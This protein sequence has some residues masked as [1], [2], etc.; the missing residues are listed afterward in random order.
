MQEVFPNIF[1]RNL[2]ELHP[3]NGLHEWA[4]L[5]RA[6]NEETVI[7]DPDHGWKTTNAALLVPIS[8]TSDS[9]SS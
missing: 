9:I 5:F 2:N 1:K 4:M 8:S 7:R 3:L 6:Y